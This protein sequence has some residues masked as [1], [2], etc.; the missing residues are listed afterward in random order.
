LRRGNKL[1]NRTEYYAA[2][3]GENRREKVTSAGERASSFERVVGK[4]AENQ[5]GG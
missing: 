2:Y 4:E 5:G 3:I 1:S